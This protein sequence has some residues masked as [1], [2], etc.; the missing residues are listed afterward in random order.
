MLVPSV[1]KPLCATD[2][3]PLA[4]PWNLQT[5]LFRRL[6]NTALKMKSLLV[7]IILSLSLFLAE[8][9]KGQYVWS[10]THPD[11]AI[12]Y[13]YYFTTLSCSGENCTAGGIYT[14]GGFNFKHAFFAFWRSN[15]G[16]NTWL[17]QDPKFGNIGTVRGYQITSIQQIDSLNVVAASDSGFLFR[18][19]DAGKTWKIQHCN[20]IWGLFDVHFSDSLTG[21]VVSGGPVPIHTTTDGGRHWQDAAFQTSYHSD[22]IQCHSYGS[23][24]F[25]VYQKPHGPIFTTNDNWKTID[26]VMIHIDSLFPLTTFDC[27]R[28][29]HFNFTGGDTMIAFGQIFYN[30][31]VGKPLLSRSS[32]AGKSWSKPPFENHSIDKL[33]CMSSLDR[34]TVIAGGLSDFPNA[35][36]FSTDRGATWNNEAITLSNSSFD[37]AWANAICLL[38]N[39]NPVASFQNFEE[40]GSNSVLIRGIQIR[41][42]VK[43]YEHI[44]WNSFL[45][46]NPT[47]TE[48]NFITPD[49][50]RPVR[51]YDLLGR[52]MLQGTT[53]SQGKFTFDVS[54]LPTGIYFVI[55]DHFGKML[56]VGKVAVIGK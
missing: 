48:L 56:P 40:R 38:P 31:K 41:S 54:K 36:L 35:I 45:Y 21:I 25:R 11:T 20:T 13:S 12:G 49:V 19:F 14:D 4:I 2:I 34:D 18:T 15:D 44:V 10:V 50:S 5:P 30:C 3:V 33:S 32:D 22:F 17:L 46:P 9:A 53:S 7:I 55:L 24:K 39:G 29:D 51:I 28:F 37:I 8:G 23:G 16:G 47:S 42:H 43:A 26:S 52:E 6:F 1:M 27:Y